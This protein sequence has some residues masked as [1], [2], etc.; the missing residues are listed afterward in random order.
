M[1]LFNG[2]K[3]KPAT[4][5]APVSER[6]VPV[7]HPG[8]YADALQEAG[9]PASQHNIDSVAQLTAINLALN[10]HQW[11][12]IMNDDSARAQF[13]S[14]FNAEAN[15]QRDPQARTADDMIDFLW[16]WSP[17]SHAGLHG[18]VESMGQTLGGAVAPYGDVLPEDL[19][20]SD[21]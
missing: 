13:D 9:K 19:W 1:G 21:S 7:L 16:A 17:K 5:P 10:A 11:F 15:S 6:G 2:N 12:R 4:T 18:F 3:S 8:F 20:N 14:Q